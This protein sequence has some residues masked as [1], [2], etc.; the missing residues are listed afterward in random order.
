MNKRALLLGLSNGFLYLVSC[1]LIATGLLLEWRL[2]EHAGGARV[3]GLGREDWGEVHFVIALVFVGF[4]A[5]HLALN[6]SWIRAS[7]ARHKPTVAVL[8]VGAVAAS[9]L[10]LWPAQQS[11][12]TA[13]RADYHDHARHH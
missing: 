13:D 8:L 4:T 5:L 7:I 10:V 11:V 12:A 6:L 3:A 1:A 9:A 2:D